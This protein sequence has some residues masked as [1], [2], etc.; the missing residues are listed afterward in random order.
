MAADRAQHVAEVVESRARAG[1]LGRDRAIL[2][3]HARLPGIRTRPRPRRARVGWCSWASRGIDAGPHDPARRAPRRW[4]AA[5]SISTAPTDSKR[6]DAGFHERV[7]AGYRALAAAD[8]DTWVVVDAS[9]HGRCCRRA[10][11]SARRR[12]AA[13]AGPRGSPVT[14]AARRRRDDDVHVD[15]RTLPV[16]GLFADVVGQADAVGQ[17]R[18]A[19]R[20]PVHAYL[21]VGTA[22]TGPA[23]PGARLRRGP[24]VSAGRVRGVRGVSTRPGRHPPRPGR[25]RADRRAS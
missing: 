19:A 20:R 4:P 23:V 25:G 1:A 5:A 12:R 11:S 18:A 17:L 16:V 22:R 3:V 21:L 9:G 6:L 8:P 2:G 24:A 10:S 7:R 15:D 14:P 13:R